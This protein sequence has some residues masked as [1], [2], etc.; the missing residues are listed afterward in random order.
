MS[1]LWD[2]LRNS[3]RS[4]LA[5]PLLTTA[6]V[7]SLVVGLGLNTAIFTFMNALFLRPMPAVHDPDQTFLTFTRIASS[8]AF[9]PVSYLNYLD[10][11]ERNRSCS[12]LAAYQMF[13]AGLTAAGVADQVNGEIVTFN[14]FPTLGHR[15]SLGRAFLETEDILHSPTPVAIISHNLWTRRFGAS[16]AVLGAKLLLNGQP[17]TIV[18]VAPVGFA[19]TTPIVKVDVWVPIAM[20]KTVLPYP[21]LVL[22]RGTQAFQPLGRLRPGVSLQT[23]ATELHRLGQQL[24]REYPDDNRGQRLVLFPLADAAV[25]PTIRPMVKRAALLLMA[26]VGLLLLMSCINIANLL[27]AKAMTRSQE[28]AVRLSLGAPRRRLVQQLLVESLLLALLG[29]AASLLFAVWSRDLLWRFRPPF[30][31]HSA[32]RLDLDFRVLGFTLGLSLLTGLF[33]G[34]F[35]AIQ[36]TRPDLLSLLKSAPAPL[37]RKGSRVTLRKLL[38][39]V[40]LCLCTLTLTATLFFVKSLYN[41]QH[42]DPGFEVRDIVTVSFDFKFQSLDEVNGRQFEQRLLEKARSLPFVQSAAIAENRL[43]GG[44]RL[45][46]NVFP[47]GRDS[48]YH[49][50]GVYSGSTLVGPDYFATVGI[51]LLSGRDFTWTDTKNSVPVAVINETMAKK[52]YPR[53]NPIGRVIL[54]E[55]EKAPV[56]IIGI[57]RNSSYTTLGQNVLPFLYLSL[58]QRYSSRVTL[59]ARVAGNPAAAIKQFKSEI[60]ALDPGMPLLEVR[61]IPAVITDSL[62]VHTLSTI[63]LTILSLIALILAALGIY[64]VAAHFVSRRQREIGVRLALGASKSGILWLVIVQNAATVLSGIAGGLLIAAL[65]KR[66]LAGFLFPS[67]SP[68]QDLLL[69]PATALLLAGVVL[70]A[71]LLPALRA[72]R[73]DPATSLRTD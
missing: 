20:Y 54:I 7:L 35:P 57:A 60:Q 67:R 13:H 10:L 40:Q 22:Q 62:W 21:E 46:E 68:L 2:D 33:F 28:M 27:L 52:L 69:M 31:E 50:G 45:W 42:F 12:Q 23:A 66:A 18:G 65:G 36:S 53:E 44:F 59:H 47:K 43:L 41:A 17:L 58:V 48:A 3:F 11:R 24:E 72:A 63:L 30:L 9:F 1:H 34:L 37:G 39:A 16:P 14:F 71:N 4:L 32:L 29:G 26:A 38:L 19:G 49:E 70:L 6:I 55:G 73:T 25:P 61:S 64:G 56:E 51:P 8:P 15:M 5:S